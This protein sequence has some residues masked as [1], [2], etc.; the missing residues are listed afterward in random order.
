MARVAT[1]CQLSR[2]AHTA[3][4]SSLGAVQV[5]AIA[6]PAGSLG[7]ELSP[8][9]GS[10]TALGTSPQSLAR[11]QAVRSPTQ[12]L[13]S[14]ENSGSLEAPLQGTGVA[15]AEPGGAAMRGDGSGWADSDF[16]PFVLDGLASANSS[17][18]AKSTLQR[19]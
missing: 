5:H 12:Q 9:P 18:N 14:R 19:R 6:A 3:T 1:V 8:L 17:L 4:L 13:L 7:L 10:P 11:L 16:A 15:L 2:L